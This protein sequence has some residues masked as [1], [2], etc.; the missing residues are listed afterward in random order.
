[1]VYNCENLNV[2]LSFFE[3]LD[4]NSGDIKGWLH[5]ANLKSNFMNCLAI[6][7]APRMNMFAAK[8]QI[9]LCAVCLLCHAPLCLR[10][11]KKRAFLWPTI[12]RCPLS[13][14]LGLKWDRKSLSIVCARTFSTY[15]RIS[16]TQSH[17]HSKK[18]GKILVVFV[19]WKIL[20][21]FCYS[22]DFSRISYLLEK[23]RNKHL[24]GLI[25]LKL[26]TFGKDRKNYWAWLKSECLKKCPVSWNDCLLV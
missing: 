15:S 4:T 13:F 12:A 1:M 25:C 17:G 8:L 23:T 11:L 26:L 10:D 5:C 3:F 24:L 18:S 19:I 20:V 7:I 21:V 14:N 22:P 6:N 2:G 16:Q 9:W